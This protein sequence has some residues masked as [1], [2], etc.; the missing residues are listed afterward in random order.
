M[1]P[2]KSDGGRTTHTRVKGCKTLTPPP[3]QTSQET[4]NTSEV[5]SETEVRW[6]VETRGDT[7]Q[8]SGLGTPGRQVL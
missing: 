7:H 2:T 6:G 3:F 1:D 5:K 8:R 4:S